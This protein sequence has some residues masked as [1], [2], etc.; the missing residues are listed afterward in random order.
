MRHRAIRSGALIAA[1]GIAVSG[2]GYDPFDSGEADQD[3]P[4]Q[5]TQQAPAFGE[6]RDE[7]FEAML[8]AE[9]VDISGE[10]EAADAD[11]DALFDGIDEDT[12][13]QLQISGAADGTE[14]QMSFSAGGSSF[15][16]RAIGGE[17]YFR[18]ED[19]AALLVSELDEEAADVVDE[20]LISGIVEDQWVQFDDAEDPSVFSAHE[21]IG[22]WQQQLGSD[23]ISE[24]AGESATRD[25][26]QVWVYTADE[27][28]SEFVLS[29]EDEPFFVSIRDGDS[30]Y[31]F[32]GWNASPAPEAPGNVISLDEIF[33]AV[34]EEQGWSAEDDVGSGTEGESGPSD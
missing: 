25:G 23:D 2:C 8:A 21:F 13:G 3:Q 30:Q 29:A 9:S 16:Q 14:S 15:T 1:A 22:T 19:F 6:I 28:E 17:E 31:E 11:L 10:I 32:S 4:A 34:A 24:M 26:Q 18:G 5:N 12:T 7:A 20:E 27:G 33:D